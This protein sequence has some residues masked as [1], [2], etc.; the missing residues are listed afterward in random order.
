M[1]WYVEVLRKYAVFDGRA[2]RR[3]YWMFQLCQLLI[4]IALSIVDALIGRMISH[5]GVLA[6]LYGLATLVPGLAVLVRRLHDTNRSGWYFFL[7]LIPL[8][9]IIILIVFLAQDGEPGPNV[10]G[11]NPKTEAA[12]PPT[13]E[14]APPI[15]PERW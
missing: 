4:V 15:P 6:N 1:N 12:Q 2:R 13:G 14:F 8:V 9:G 7:C 11:P 3:E 5:A 10:Y